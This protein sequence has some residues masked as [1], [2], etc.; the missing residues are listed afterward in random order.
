M[1][2]NRML[3]FCGNVKVISETWGNRICQKI[4]YENFVSVAL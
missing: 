2:R 3:H 4:E 1:L